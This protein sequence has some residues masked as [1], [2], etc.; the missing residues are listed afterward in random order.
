MD[1]RNFHHFPYFCFYYFDYRGQLIEFLR[2]SDLDIRKTKRQFRVI[3]TLTAENVVRDN[4]F[5]D[6]LFSHAFFFMLKQNPR[7]LSR[8]VTAIGWRCSYRDATISLKRD[9]GLLLAPACRAIFAA[10]ASERVRRT[11]HR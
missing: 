8:I 5:H 7:D 11:A 9:N 2:S 3:C 10:R 1:V 6:F 4:C